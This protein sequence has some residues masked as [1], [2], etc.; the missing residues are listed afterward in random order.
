MSKKYKKIIKK[1]FKKVLTLND[2]YAKIKNVPSKK[3][4]RTKS[5]LKSKQYPLRDQ[6]GSQKYYQKQ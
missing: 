2:D 4:Q 5:T 3:K 6:A 1:Y